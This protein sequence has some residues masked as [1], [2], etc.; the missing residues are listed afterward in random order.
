MTLQDMI[1][2]LLTPAGAGLL[3]TELL[4]HGQDIPLLGRLVRRFQAARPG[5]KRWWAWLIASCFGLAVLGI[6]NGLGLAQITGEAIFAV[7]L[8]ANAVSQLWH[9]ARYAT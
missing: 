7:I 4:E 3:L 6:G 2:Y 1:V 5:S 9:G 8:M